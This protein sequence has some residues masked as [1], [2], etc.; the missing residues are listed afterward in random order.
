MIS[1]YFTYDFYQG[2]LPFVIFKLFYLC[3]RT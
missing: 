3:K 2:F 1:I